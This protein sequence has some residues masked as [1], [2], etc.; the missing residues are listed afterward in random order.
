MECKTSEIEVSWNLARSRRQAGVSTA[1]I[2]MFAD[3]IQKPSLLRFGGAIFRS[4]AIIALTVGLARPQAGK[5]QGA[6]SADGVDIVLVIDTSG[7]M[8]A[9]DFVI[10]GERPTRLEVI[11]RVIGDF[12]SARPDDRIGIVVFGT[13]AFTQAPLTLDHDVLL[14]FLDQVEIGVAGEATAIGDGLGTAVARLKDQRSNSREGS[15]VVVL[16]TDGANNAGRMD[17]MAATNAAKALGVRV[18]TVGVGSKGE[19]PIISNG[20]MVYIKADIDEKLLGAIAAETGGVYR[21]VADTEG[22]QGVYSEID[23]LEKKRVEIKDQR[24]GRDYF[25]AALVASILFIVL[26][27]M[28]RGSR[29]RVVPQ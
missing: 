3:C 27:M 22:L 14:R 25:A 8:K 26:E 4:L 6:R 18:H 13:E 11:K 1:S 23:R 10:G 2:K 28:W 16:L 15:R 5:R 19:V 7:S 21:R 29:W 17:P 12:I 20:Q 24:S 9:R